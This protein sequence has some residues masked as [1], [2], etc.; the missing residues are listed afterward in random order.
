MRFYKQIIVCLCGICAMTT[1]LNAQETAIIAEGYAAM[2]ERG[3]LVP[4][5]FPRRP[6][7]ERDLLVEILYCGVC[8]SDIHEAANDWHYTQYPNVPGHEIVGKVIRTGEGT[9]LFRVG[10][11]IGI[12]G[13]VVS[14]GE[15]DMCLAGKEH[16]CVAPP[17]PPAEYP[18]AI[19]GYSDKIVVDERY[20]IHIPKDAPLEKIGPLMCAGITVYSPLKARVKQGD[21]VAIAGFGGLGHM[22]VHYA[23]A[24]GAEVSVFDVSEEKRPFAQQFG[25]KQ[26]INVTRP[27]FHDVKNRFD[28]ILTTIPSRYDIAPYLRM[29]KPE[30]ELLLVG[31]PAEK[32]GPLINIHDIPFGARISKWLMGSIRETQEMVDFSLAYGIMPQVEVIPIQQINEA[33]RKV[34]EGKVQFRYVIDMKSIG[35][36]QSK[37]K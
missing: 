26:Y 7:G 16:L 10:D 11:Y 4:Y 31:L 30:G 6:V 21:K 8:H 24:L 27:E 2:D 1:D 20:G 37:D 34:Q 32:D 5:R 18:V 22:A 28:Y 36:S 14:C 33:F 25:A 13:T 9:S 29:L 12:G 15:C 19:G 3:E 23:V 35:H 17:T